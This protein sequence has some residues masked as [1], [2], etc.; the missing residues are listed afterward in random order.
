MSISI[1]TSL[2]N[3]KDIFLPVQALRDVSIE[4]VLGIDGIRE[5]AT[6]ECDTNGLSRG[7]MFFEE[8]NGIMTPAEISFV[9]GEYQ[10]SISLTFCQFVWAVG[11]YM[12]AYFDNIIQIPNMNAAGTNIHGYKVDKNHVEYANEQFRLARSL[13][14]GYNHD[15]FFE[16]PN[17]CDPMEY[18][19]PIGK[20]NGVF[21]GGVAFMFC[22]ELS[23]NI[24]GHTQKD[25][26]DDESVAE[27]AA[28]DD[29]ALDML[30]DTFDSN[31]GFNHKVG[32]ATVLCSLLM[33][34]EDSISGGSRHPHMDY[35]IQMMMKK[36][37]LHKM[38]SL[39]G[40]VGSVIRLWLL[41]YGGLTIQEDMKTGG[42]DFYQNFYEHYLGLLTQVRELRYPKLVKP[43]WYVE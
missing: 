8:R 25:S 23:H 42:F 4:H 43:I 31:W 11:L 14:W 5:A 16:L 20:A 27:E 30:S 29:Y 15:V 2:F 36:F 37:N 26:T 38:D 34:G 18:S 10:I 1:Q 40:F 22:H 35:R 12:T 21:L 13:M 9:N 17:I 39:W 19:E 3:Y 7:I 33:M 32:A 6:I 28:A 41:V 24:L